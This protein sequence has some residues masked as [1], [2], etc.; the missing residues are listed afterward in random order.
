[1]D[2]LDVV[3]DQHGVDLLIGGHDHVSASLSLDTADVQIYYV[4]GS[5]RILLIP[6]RQGCDKVGWLC[7]GPRR[8]RDGG[9]PRCQV[10]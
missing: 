5:A 10:S 4:R 1:M 9:R 6:D 7:R 2:K 8:E 3:R